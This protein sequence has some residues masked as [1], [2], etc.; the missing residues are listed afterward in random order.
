[1]SQSPG[2]GSLEPCLQLQLIII[3]VCL[4]HLEIWHQ[5]L[6]EGRGDTPNAFGITLVIVLFSKKRDGYK[7]K[8]K[9]NI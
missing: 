4:C 3:F 6:M 8:K 2:G 5:K 9:K 1:M 7:K